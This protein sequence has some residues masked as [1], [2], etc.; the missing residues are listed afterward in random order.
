MMGKYDEEEEAGPLV[1]STATPHVDQPQTPPPT[2]ALTDRSADGGVIPAPSRS[3]GNF[4]DLLEDGQL[5][6]DMHQQLQDLAA[7]MRAVANSTGGKAKGEATLK[8]KLELEGDAFKIQ[9]DVKI[10]APDL[11][12]RRSIMWQDDSGS[13]TRFPPNQT[14]MFGTAQVRRIG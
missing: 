11:P 1:E 8:L 4:L 2:R 9:G 7:Q 3:A 6:A 13:F 12:R 10:K 14:Q 5:S